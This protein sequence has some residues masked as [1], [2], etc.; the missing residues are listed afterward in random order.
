[1]CWHV[2]GNRSSYPALKNSAPAGCV[3]CS[4]FPLLD[5]SHRPSSFP[6]SSVRTRL[7]LKHA[8]RI[9]TSRLSHARRI[10][11]AFVILAI[12]YVLISPLPELSANS[13]RHTLIAALSLLTLSVTAATP[14]PPAA[15]DAYQTPSRCTP[16]LQAVL[17]SRHC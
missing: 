10:I 14:P 4:S 3:C 2:R 17:C 12:L 6:D 5:F 8:T 13:P 7:M 16:D 11:F 1:M 15:Q 9:W